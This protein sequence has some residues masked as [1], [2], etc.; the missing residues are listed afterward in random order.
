MNAP[1]TGAQDASSI[2]HPKTIDLKPKSG[3]RKCNGT[4]RLGF[5]NGDK[6]QAIPC[7]CIRKQAKALEASGK[8]DRDTRINVATDGSSG[9]VGNVKPTI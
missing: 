9:P 7:K 8:L 1:E 6:N 5:L 2:L 3:C 4:G